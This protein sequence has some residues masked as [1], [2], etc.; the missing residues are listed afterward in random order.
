[1]GSLNPESLI[2]VG[3]KAQQL[4]KLEATQALVQVSLNLMEQSVQEVSS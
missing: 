4:A 2:A 3:E 1:L